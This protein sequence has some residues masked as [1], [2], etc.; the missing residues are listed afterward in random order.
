M[1]ARIAKICLSAVAGMLALASANAVPIQN[2]VASGGTGSG[3]YDAEA[4]FT[5]G[6]GTVTLVLKNLQQDPISAA[7]LISGISFSISGLTGNAVLSSGSGN[8]AT[9]NANGTYTPPASPT[10]PLPRW[11][12][13]GTSGTTVSMT[14]LGGGQPSD[15]IIGPDSLGG[16]NGAGTYDKQNSS[17]GNF[18]P[19]I[20]GSAAFVFTLT[21][22]TADSVITGV[23]FAFGTQPDFTATGHTVKVPDGGF[24]MA[25]LGTGLVGL[26]LVQRRFGKKK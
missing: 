20:L 5:V 7:Q 2:F 8:I 23:T 24:T 12:V 4:D 19:S 18:Q 15:L 1:K 11:H 13:S 16:F 21:H 14:A 9:V 3:A 10:S 22:V 25:M 26:G 17:I 6:N